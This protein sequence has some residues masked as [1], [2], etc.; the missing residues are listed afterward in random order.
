[1]NVFILLGGA[2]LSFGIFQEITK[3]KGAKAPAKAAEVVPAEKP[4]TPFVPVP[5]N[6]TEE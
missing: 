6:K 3:K 2:L 5:T 4:V 1:M